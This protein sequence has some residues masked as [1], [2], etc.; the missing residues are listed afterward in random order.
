[1]RKMAHPCYGWSVVVLEVK[2]S[3][4]LLKRFIRLVLQT[5]INLGIDHRAQW[6]AAMKTFSALWNGNA[7]LIT[8]S[9]L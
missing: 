8:E 3:L 2:S 5:V 4:S 7:Q 6:C 1:M 9:P